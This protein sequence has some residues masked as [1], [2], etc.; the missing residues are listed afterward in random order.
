MLDEQFEFAIS[1][2]LDGTLPESERNA[3]DAR[4]A[5]DSDARAV[6]AEY[7]RLDATLRSTSAA[8][9]ELRWDT[10]AEHISA[11]I[12]HDERE[13]LL[14]PISNAASRSRFRLVPLAAAAAF[15]LASG[16]AVLLFQQSNP[17]QPVI[18]APSPDSQVA[19]VE[20]PKPEVAAGPSE[21]IVSSIGPAFVA[22][23]EVRLA[24]SIVN[25]PSRVV[26]IA[27]GTDAVQDKEP[28]LY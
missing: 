15:V 28:A 7:R 25:R 22:E 18:P 10:L 27:S 19:F 23:E 6:L 17:T 8:I 14:M 13:R 11:S 16:I 4:L 5:T 21:T 12:D 20:G 2:Y 26:W 9:P 1:Q 24:E 3:L